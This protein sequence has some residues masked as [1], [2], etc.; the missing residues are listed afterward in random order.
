MN[1]RRYVEFRC[2]SESTAEIESVTFEGREHLVVPVVALIGDS[3]IQASNA[4]TPEY[5]PAGVVAASIQSWDGRPVVPKHPKLNGIEVSANSPKIFDSSRMGFIFETRFEDN[6]L[7]MLSYLDIARCNEL[8]GD[9]KLAIDKLQAGEGIDVSVGGIVETEEVKGGVTL[10]AEEYGAIWVELSGDHLAFL[11]SSRGACNQS[12]GCGA[13]RIAN[14]KETDTMPNDNPPVAVDRAAEPKR[15][16][17]SRLLTKFRPAMIFD[18]GNSDD[19]LRQSLAEA[20]KAADP[21]FDWICA[22]YAESGVVIYMTYIVQGYGMMHG[23]YQ[24]W[25]RTFTLDESGKKVTVNNDAIEVQPKRVWETVDEGIEVGP[26]ESGSMVGM[27]SVNADVNTD[28]KQLRAA[29]CACKGEKTMAT[30]ESRKTAIDGLVSAGRF[31]E[32]DRKMLEGLS[33][34]GWKT[35]TAVEE[36]KEE[37]EP[38]VAASAAADIPAPTPAPPL[39]EASVLAAFPDLNRIVTGYRAAETKRKAHLVTHLSS[40]QSVY[41]E[42]AL[43]SKSLDTLEE[44]A[45]LVGL[46]DPQPVDFSLR[47]MP[48]DSQAETRVANAPAPDGW[49]TALEKSTQGQKAN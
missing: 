41:S 42:E 30:A 27:E 39:T 12:M 34:A 28:S 17:F 32:E 26:R 45:K 5:I 38:V 25:R 13:P 1:N 7:K 20:I 4:L 18:D 22:V 23:M 21:A 36:K 6:K 29:E 2:S 15:D 16:F 19:E 47:G 14:E 24:Y 37:K 11:P 40:A 35:L 43:K 33:E 10:A 3:V 44:I 31:V 48:V 9:A 8:G 46:E 49:R